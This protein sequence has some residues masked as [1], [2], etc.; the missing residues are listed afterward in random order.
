MFV[1]HFSSFLFLLYISA[2]VQSTIRLARDESFPEIPNMVWFHRTKV[3]HARACHK[4]Y[5]ITVT[6][7]PLLVEMAP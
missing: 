6:P 4:T 2:L 3:V 1:S 5:T 7:W